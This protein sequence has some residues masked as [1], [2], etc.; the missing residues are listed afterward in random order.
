MVKSWR[1]CGVMFPFKVVLE[2]SFGVST[3]LKYIYV[4][5]KRFDVS[6]QQLKRILSRAIQH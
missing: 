5:R 4:R 6:K 2:L 1:L 3:F